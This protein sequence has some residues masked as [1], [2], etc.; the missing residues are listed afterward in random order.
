MLVTDVF[1]NGKTTSFS[2]SFMF[3]FSQ[4]VQSWQ[5]KPWLQTLCFL[6]GR[7]LICNKINQEQEE[8]QFKKINS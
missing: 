3:L 6:V 5:Q 2:S 1:M 4:C 8:E 7:M